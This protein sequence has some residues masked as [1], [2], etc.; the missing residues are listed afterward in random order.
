MDPKD[1]NEI[2]DHDRTREKLRQTEERFQ[3]LVESIQ[4]YAIYILDPPWL[5]DQLELW[6]PAHKGV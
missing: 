5:R 3:V 4:D 6:C 2:G 1:R